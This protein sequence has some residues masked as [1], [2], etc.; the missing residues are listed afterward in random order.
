MDER[1]AGIVAAAGYRRRW[2]MVSPDSEGCE[3]EILREMEARGNYL[4]PEEPERW[5][6]K[7]QPRDEEQRRHAHPGMA[8][9]PP[10]NFDRRKLCAVFVGRIQRGY[11][12]SFPFAFETHQDMRLG[13]ASETDIPTRQTTPIRATTTGQLPT[14]FA[15][16]SSTPICPS[17]S[18]RCRRSTVRVL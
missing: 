7:D 18:A 1:R 3:E 4:Q 14:I 8:I 17:H 10:E 16:P 12:L 13:T 11:A 6:G 15:T 2:R 5:E 9:E